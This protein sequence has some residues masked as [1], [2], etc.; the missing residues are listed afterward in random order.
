[1]KKA[2]LINKERIMKTEEKKEN[3]FTKYKGEI[4]LGILTLY[5]LLLGL[6]TI[7]EVFKVEWILNLPIFK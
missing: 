3:I 7:G 6:G 1:M 5:V 4:L 2:D